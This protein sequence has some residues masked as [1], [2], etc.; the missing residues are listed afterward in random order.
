MHHVM[1]DIDGTLVQSVKMDEDCFNRAV[2]RVLNIDVEEDWSTYPHV[3]DAGI[4]GTVTSD[5]D[6]PYRQEAQ[7]EVKTEFIRLLQEHLDV[8]PVREIKGA[9]RFLSELR[10]IEGVTLSIATGGWYESALLKLNSAQLDIRDIPLS[11]S[12]D[13]FDRVEIMKLARAR[14]GSMPRDRVTYFGDGPWDKEACSRLGYNF[15]LVGEGLDHHKKISE[16][17]KISEILE[18]IGL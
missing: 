6:V 2:K 16:Y 15:V 10:K 8:Q 5:L 7:E 4:L 17:T 18:H 3:S 11:S 1:F 14:S 13:H 12:D 9:S